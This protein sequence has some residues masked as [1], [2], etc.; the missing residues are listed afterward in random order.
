MK[1]LILKILPALALLSGPAISLAQT[2]DYRDQGTID[3]TFKTELLN[4]GFENGEY[5]AS[6]PKFEITDNFIHIKFVSALKPDGTVATGQVTVDI[7]TDD[8]VQ[9]SALACAATIN[10]LKMAAGGDLSRIRKIANI[11]YTTFTVADWWDYIPGSN[12][13]SEMI[14]R[15]FGKSAGSHTRHAEGH[16]TSEGNETYRIEML[17]YLK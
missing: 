14:L 2:D 1:I 12:S 6:E 16:G 10:Q 4:L 13:C 9:A 11:R 3:A 7:T 15:V 8:V 5:P 17:A